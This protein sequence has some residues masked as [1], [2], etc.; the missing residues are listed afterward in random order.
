M[1]TELFYCKYFLISISLIHLLQKSYFYKYSTFQRTFSE[2]RFSGGNLNQCLNV[3]KNLAWFDT[4]VTIKVRVSQLDR[5]NSFWENICQTRVIFTPC[6][7]E[8][9]AGGQHVKSLD[10]FVGSKVSFRYDKCFRFYSTTSS[11]LFK[12]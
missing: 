3:F 2:K 1:N 7:F 6:S 5:A 4:I 12:T 10:V 8:K 11:E 9:D